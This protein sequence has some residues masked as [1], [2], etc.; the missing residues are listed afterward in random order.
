MWS[1]LDEENTSRAVEFIPSYRVLKLLHDGMPA[2]VAL[3]YT[4]R[5]RTSDDTND[6]R[7]DLGTPKLT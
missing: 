1:N 7:T 2:R 5:D 4:N 6:W 3:P